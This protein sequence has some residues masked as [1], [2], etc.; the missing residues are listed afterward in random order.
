MICEVWETVEI[1]ERPSTYRSPSRISDRL[2]PRVPVN[3]G[4][5]IE[6]PIRSTRSA[7]IGMFGM[8]IRATHDADSRSQVTST[9]RAGAR[10]VMPDSSRPLSAYGSVVSAKTS[11]VSSAEPVCRNTMTARATS[12]N[13]VPS[14]ESTWAANIARNSRTANTAPYPALLFFS[15]WVSGE[16][17]EPDCE[18]W[19]PSRD[20]CSLS[21]VMTS[22]WWHW[23]HP[24]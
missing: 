21:V 9:R 14:I 13:I 19:F 2:A 7:A 20:G 10:S 23:P 8:T 16:L 5:M 6:T 12:Q 15:P 11:A 3:S 4:E 17:S 24:S 18:E 1:S 22:H